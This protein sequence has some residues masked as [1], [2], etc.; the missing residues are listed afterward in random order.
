MLDW[1]KRKK[2]KPKSPFTR[3]NPAY[4][5]YTIGEYTY[6]TPRVISWDRSEQLTIGRYCSIASEVV[7]LLGG[8]HRL[9]WLSTYPFN[10]MFET[11]KTLSGQPVSK[12]PVSIGH[13]VWIGHG[14]QIFSGV[15]V[16]NGAVIGGGAVV[17]RD[18]PPYAIV[19]GN[20][21]RV[22]RYRFDEAQ[23]ALLQSIA[24]WDW[25]AEK[26]AAAAPVLMSGDLD[27]LSR[28]AAGR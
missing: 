10:K 27:A 28:L 15:T 26:V 18:V 11:A 20:P 24:W 6:G 3:D 1:M 23:I 25:P 5:R 8:E 12:G 17:A 9:D 22:I 2:R 21:A 16:G 14:A 7:I 19:A 4:A 13:D